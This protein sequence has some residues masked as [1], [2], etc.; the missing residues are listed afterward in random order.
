MNFFEISP[1]CS[2]TPRTAAGCYLLILG[3]SFSVAGVFALHGYW[4]V[5]PFAGLEMLVLALAWLHVMRRGQ[6]RDFIRIDETT[7]TVSKLE[8]GRQTRYEFSRPWTRV[9]L[10][11]AQVASWPS[12]LTIACMGRR[13]EVGAFLTE[14]ERRR[15]RR[16]L[17]ELLPEEPASLGPAPVNVK[18]TKNPGIL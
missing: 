6:N 4:P 17:V 15:L 14:G 5:L 2:L 8:D 16:R 10:H 13:V 3:T 9:E 18:L 7:V 1:N 12:R 11:G